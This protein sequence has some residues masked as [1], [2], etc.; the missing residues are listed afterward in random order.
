MTMKEPPD[1][2]DDAAKEA[3]HAA[4][5]A[6]QAVEVARQAQSETATQR[7]AEIASTLAVERVTE[8][9]ID[10]QRMGEVVRQQIEHVLSRGSEQ[11]GA[12][13]L[14]RVPYICQDIKEMKA[15]IQGIEANIEDKFVTRYEFSPV[16]MLTY[17]IVGLLLT[18]TIGA[19]VAAVL[20]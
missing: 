14:A 1:F 13:I 9:I 4:K 19:M 17:G 11:Q 7:A 10:E 18:A 15:A 6:A 5:N 16:R 3:V 8:K 2:L 12:L 20:K